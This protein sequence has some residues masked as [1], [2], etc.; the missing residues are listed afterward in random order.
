MQTVEE[1]ARLIDET[2]RK[3]KS[4]EARQRM[5]ELVIK[6]G[7]VSDASRKLWADYLAKGCPAL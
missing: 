4:L 7:Y 5:A 6:R 3:T 1:T 2:A